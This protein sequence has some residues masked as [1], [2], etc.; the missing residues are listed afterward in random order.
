M[1][2]LLEIRATALNC[3]TRLVETGCCRHQEFQSVVLMLV[4]FL[5]TGV[6]SPKPDHNH[7]S[8]V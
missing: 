8:S 4:N 1:A 3:A 5:V 2:D 6:F 7:S